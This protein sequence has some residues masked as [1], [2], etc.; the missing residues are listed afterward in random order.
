MNRP[1]KDILN[2]LQR[3]SRSSP[4]YIEAMLSA[5]KQ[6]IPFDAAC[7]TAVDPKTLL[8]IGAVTDD[9]IEAIHPQLFEL[10]YADEDVNRFVALIQTRQTAAILSETVK[11]DLRQSKRYRNILEPAGFGDELRA[12]LLSKGECWGYLTLL[13]KRGQPLFTEKD[14]SLL[15]SLAPLIGR[16]LQQFRH[17]LSKKDV[18]HMKHVGGI[19]ILSEDLQPLS[20]NRAALHWLNILRGWERIGNEAVPRPVRAVCTRAAAKTAA[21]AKTIISIP[22]YSALSIK[23]SRLDG[24]GPSGQIAVSFEPASPAETIPLIAEAYSLSDREKDI[25]YRVIRGL[26]T[27]AIGDELH[28]SAYTVQDHLKSIF[29]KTGA[30]NRRELMWKLLDDVLE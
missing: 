28:I 26:S 16:H 18:F 23:A 21:P 13:R 22:G 9:Q 7:C 14:K 15:A 6:T 30:G 5:L 4:Q 20:C 12:V 25:A 17:H 1:L 10:E 29:L 3:T 24:F 8:S 11:G 2:E 19:L 27:K